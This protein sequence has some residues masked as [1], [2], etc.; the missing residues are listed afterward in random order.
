MGESRFPV[1]LGGHISAFLEG[2]RAAGEILAR[3]ASRLALKTAG[4]VLRD[5]EDA[6]DVA[7]EV[8]VEALRSLKGLRDPDAFDAWVHKITVRVAS[9]AI[10][11]R[12]RHGSTQVSLDVA[13]DAWDT[14]AEELDLDYVL[15]ARAGLVAA[16]AR[17]PV[18]Q[19]LALTL[20]Y[21]HDLSDGE[22]AEALGCRIGTVHALLSRA[23]N[24]LRADPS[25][26]CFMPAIEDAAA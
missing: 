5:R 3:R 10:A 18:R 6:G 17:L 15:S 19:R 21:V 1:G 12:E 20:R 23:R 7:Q 16:L 14:R 8:V 22:I 9:R 11:K 26:G 2:D 24:A 4:A 25:L 13:P